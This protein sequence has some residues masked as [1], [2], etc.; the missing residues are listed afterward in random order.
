MVATTAEPIGSARSKRRKHR[1][2]V[3]SL[4]VT[5]AWENRYLSWILGTSYH[6]YDIE[7]P[8]VSN[9]GMNAPSLQSIEPEHPVGGPSN[10]KSQ[11]QST[12]HSL[13]LL[14]PLL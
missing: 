10:P 7:C 3:S 2:T 13:H 8:A 1:N 12:F 6:T 4:K 11:G 9:L 14:H 5:K